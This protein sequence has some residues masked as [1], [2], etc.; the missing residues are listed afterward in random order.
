MEIATLEGDGV[1]FNFS[2][3]YAIRDL[4]RELQQQ[5]EEMIVRKETDTIEDEIATGIYGDEYY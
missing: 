2:N 4:I 5:R 3:T 1:P